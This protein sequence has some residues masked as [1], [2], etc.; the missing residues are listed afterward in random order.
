[1][2]RS[3]CSVIV[4]MLFDALIA[5]EIFEHFLIPGTRHR[6]TTSR[7]PSPDLDPASPEELRV[8]GTALGVLTV[9]EVTH[10]P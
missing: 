5:P 9:M 1:M 2:Y 3:L 8:P 10:L 6:R 4:I 7:C